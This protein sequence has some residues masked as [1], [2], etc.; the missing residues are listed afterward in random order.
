MPTKSPNQEVFSTSEHEED[1]KKR[2]HEGVWIPQ[3]VYKETSSWKIEERD[4]QSCNTRNWS[5]LGNKPLPRSNNSQ[6]EGLRSG[7]HPANHQTVLNGL[8][9]TNQR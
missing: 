9:I 1:N 5:V 8:K 2:K 4:E 6:S 3:K 7:S